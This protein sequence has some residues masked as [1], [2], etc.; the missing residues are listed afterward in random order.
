MAPAMNNSNSNGNN[1]C[2][3]KVK[4]GQLLQEEL[5]EEIKDSNRFSNA[6][7]ISTT[8]SSSVSPRLSS[9]CNVDDTYDSA[10]ITAS[11]YYFNNNNMAT[12]SPWSQ[13]SSSPY[14]KSPW[15]K[16]SSY[17]PPTL[18]INN[19][20]NITSP[21][22]VY[23]SRGKDALIGSLLR[24]EGHVYSLAAKEGMLYTG[25]ESKNIRVWNNFNDAG[26]FKSGSGLVKAIIISKDDR[27]FTGHQDGKIRIWNAKGKRI[28][29]LPKLGD[30]LRSSINP[31]KYVQ[32]RR[33]HKVPKVKHFDAVSCMSLNEEA[34]LLY[35]GSWD[36]SIKVW[37][38][39]DG[40]CMESIEAHDDAINSI[41]VGFNG[42]VFSGSAD[43][44]V[45]VW[46]RELDGRNMRHVHVTTLLTQ[47]NAVTA[48]AVAETGED[49][50]SGYGFA[51][52]AGSSDGLVNFWEREKE[53]LC[54][55]GVLRGHKMAVLCLAT[56]G[57]LVMSGSAD[58]TICVWKRE[59][60]GA[61]VHSCLSVLTGHSG[62]VKCLAVELDF[63]ADEDGTGTEAEAEAEQWV[64]YSGSLDKS[65]K[66]WRVSN[67]A[68]DD[69][70]SY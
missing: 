53:E 48:L 69:A 67:H 55:G 7:E 30:Y 35:S 5:V 4:F 62:P 12:M 33:H 61:G 9:F 66:I 50:E 56:A 47:E 64:V 37:R 54:Y 8:T 28:G 14:T 31:N 20:N 60:D 27:V 70:L 58:K 57:N 13:A 41:V 36:K 24:E 15:I 6:S 63:D 38:I 68:P 22:N 44:T 32:V 3:R 39:S 10:S 29:T 17:P 51:L 2:I 52:Y 11:P 23:L 26:G 40:K 65:V 25:S 16:L 45:K 59:E 43:G 18:N 42:L 34:G 46:R 21:T 49:Y 1:N 19:N